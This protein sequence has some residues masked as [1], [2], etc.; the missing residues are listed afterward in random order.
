[1]KAHLV[2]TS[3]E[4]ELS[5]GMPP[6]VSLFPDAEILTDNSGNTDEL[7]TVSR[8]V[9]ATDTID[10]IHN[11]V[12]QPNGTVI[13]EKLD[14]PAIRRE[15]FMRR[16]AEKQRLVEASVPVGSPRP[17]GMSAMEAGPSLLQTKS[18]EASN[19]DGKLTS[20]EDF[21]D[22]SDLSELSE[23]ESQSLE[24]E[25]HEDAAEDL[26]GK[27]PADS[28]KRSPRKKIDQYPESTIGM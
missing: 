3:V 7:R 2:D 19:K 1:M 27:E 28:K 15:R 11:V 25:E 8:A 9:A 23:D 12:T 13:I 20:Y 5:P 22:E 26:P 4:E 16:K 10:I 18:V 21:E 17:D 14:T 24:I 6:N